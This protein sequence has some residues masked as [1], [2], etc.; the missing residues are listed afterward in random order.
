MSIHINNDE[1]ETLV[2]KYRSRLGTTKTEAIRR[3]VELA[4][5]EPDRQQSRSRLLET[6][7][8][9]ITQARAEKRK[10]FTKQESDALFSYL[11]TKE[12]RR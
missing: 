10:P 3:A 6:G 11:E 2:E 5:K 8:A 12:N 7:L 9:I 4:L 1:V